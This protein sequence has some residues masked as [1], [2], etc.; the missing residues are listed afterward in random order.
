[1][2]NRQIALAVAL[3]DYFSAPPTLEDY[4]N[5]EIEEL[6]EKEYIA[7]WQPFEYWSLGDVFENVESL[8]DAIERVLNAK[9]EFYAHMKVGK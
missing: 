7:I 4:E 8:A 2:T 1:M 9:D 5:L 6:E 3:D